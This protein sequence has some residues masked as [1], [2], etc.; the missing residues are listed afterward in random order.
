MADRD[1]DA[2]LMPDMPD[3]DMGDIDTDLSENEQ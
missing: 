3:P 2:D 1:E